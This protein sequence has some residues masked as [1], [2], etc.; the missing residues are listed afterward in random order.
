MLALALPRSTWL[1][2]LSLS[3]ARSAT[4]LS[5]ARRRWRIARSRSP[6]LTSAGTARSELVATSWD[7]IKEI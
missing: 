5:V 6:T 4:V 7:V 2:K 1:R 3:P